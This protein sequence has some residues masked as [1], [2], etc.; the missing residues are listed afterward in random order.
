MKA[1][2]LTPSQIATVVRHVSG[3][4]YGNNV[5]FER[6]P[7]QITKNCVRFTLRTHD[8]KK[9]GSRRS[10]SGRHMAKACWHV[11]RDV[12]G[13]LFDLEPDARIVTARADYRGKTSFAANF[14]ATGDQNI[15]SM[16]DPLTYCDACDC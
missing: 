1:Y 11:H 8:S 16:M 12:L 9:A 14:A 13:A 15:G 4:C 2:G 6:S 10:Q 5:T 7:E 3:N